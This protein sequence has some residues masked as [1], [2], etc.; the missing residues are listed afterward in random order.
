MKHLYKAAWECVR[1]FLGAPGRGAQ[2][3]GESAVERLL[4]ERRERGLGRPAE[5]TC[6]DSESATLRCA[7]MGK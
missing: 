6:S 3:V 4:H 1:G 2:V 7:T 5:A